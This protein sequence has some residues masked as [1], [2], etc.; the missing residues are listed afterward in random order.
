ML[1]MNYLIEMYFPVYGIKEEIYMFFSKEVRIARLEYRINLLM[2]RG[3]VMNQRLIAAL[4]REK[5]ALE[6]DN[7]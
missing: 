4:T 6:N 1:D 2:S 7:V 3:E 5:R